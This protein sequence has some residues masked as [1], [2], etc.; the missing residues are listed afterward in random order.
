MDL[1]EIYLSLWK[2]F[3][4]ETGK[5]WIKWEKSP[6]ACDLGIIPVDKHVENVDYPLKIHREY[7]ATPD[8]L[9]RDCGGAASKF[10]KNAQ[11]LLV[12]KHFFCYT[13]IMHNQESCAK[14]HTQENSDV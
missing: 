5:L 6:K 3:Y 4:S 2:D 14:L 7:T 8:G 11:S 9:C 13:E 10:Y 12:W 1:I